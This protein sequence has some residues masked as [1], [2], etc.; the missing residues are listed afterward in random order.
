MAGLFTNSTMWGDVI[1]DAGKEGGEGFFR[2]PMGQNW[3]K[4]TDSKI[5]DMQN[6]GG[7]Y[8]GSTTAA[9]FLYRFVDQ[10]TPWAH[11][12]I[13]GMAWNRT[14]KDTVPVGA[15]GFGVA[16]LYNLVNSD[17]PSEMPIDEPMKY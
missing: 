8:G 9:E 15:V 14:A 13:A 4:M 3:N 12:D 2:M 7:P 10:E 5:A 16:T 1:T 11:L 6:I 17:F